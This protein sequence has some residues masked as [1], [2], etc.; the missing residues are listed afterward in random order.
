[1]YYLR[2]GFAVFPT[3]D[4]Y[5]Q[6]TVLQAFSETSRVS[7]LSTNNSLNF[8]TEIPFQYSEWPGL[9]AFALSFT[10]ITGMPLFPAALIAIPFG[11]FSVWFLL[12]YAL[13]RAVFTKILAIKTSGIIAS[14]AMIIAAD[15]PNFEFPPEF[16]YDF[17][18]LTFMLAAI[19]ILVD[20]LNVRRSF[21][22]ISLLLAI[23]TVSI[24]VTHSLT[25]L[26][27][28]LLLVLFG[29]LITLGPKLILVLSK[30]Y[31]SLTLG[32]KFVA[33][34]KDFSVIRLTVFVVIATITW[35]AFFATFSLDYFG[36]T[37]SKILSSFS[38][39]SIFQSRLPGPAGQILSHLT[40]GWLLYDMKIRD[41]VFLGLIL[42]G[43]IALVARPRILGTRR[44]A[45]LLLSIV[46]ISIPPELF[47]T[48][49]FNDRPLL[50]FS[51]FL[52]LICVI[53]LVLLSNKRSSLMKLGAAIIAGIFLF[54]AG[55]GFWGASYS[56]TYLYSNNTSPF[57]FGEHPTDWADV[58]SY[59]RYAQENVFRPSPHSVRRE[60]VSAR[61]L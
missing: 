2:T 4:S 39:V 49:N 28:S 54:T 44:I 30:I 41:Y 40:P 7:I 35:W 29:I 5:G 50:V 17:L 11:I 6:Y 31:R 20:S 36:Y 56:P 51:S 23:L 24:V 58:A 59:V 19:L 27:W 26:F 1:M 25:A 37:R 43:T 53:P 12:T 22:K 21:G 13:L 10:R 32:T 14:V 61:L 16:K 45:I 9:H 60:A 15:Q 38:L 55:V 47:Q 18:A 42:L 8:L 46:L 52:G 57:A 33:L 34:R 3:G 48:I